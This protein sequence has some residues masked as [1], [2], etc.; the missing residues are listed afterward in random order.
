MET[1]EEGGNNA[2]VWQLPTRL[3]YP[4]I[5]LTRPL[6]KDTEKIAKW[7]ASMAT[8]YKRETGTIAGDAR[9]RHRSSPPWGLLDVVPV[10]WTGPSLN[11]RPAQDPHRDHRDRPPRLPSHRGRGEDRAM[12]PSPVGFDAAGP[13]DR[14]RRAGS[15]P[16]LEHAYLQL[17]EPSKDGSLSKPGAR[18]RQASTSSSTP[19]S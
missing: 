2:S 10:R 14:P 13:A 12:A 6:G 3:K 8:G 4:N 11:R 17:H 1:R 15:R 7:F 18:D 5:K 19:R 16:K 9:R